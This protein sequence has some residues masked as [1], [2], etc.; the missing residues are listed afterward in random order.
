MD[1]RTQ[2]L[3]L[4]EVI[5]ATLLGGL[6]G[7]EREVASKPAGLRTHMLVALSATVL[8]NLGGTVVAA[9]PVADSVAADPIRIIQAV[10]V[11]VSFLGAGTILQRESEGHVQGLTTAASLLAAAT[12]GIAVGLRLFLLA[13]GTTALILV[14]NRVVNYLDDWLERRV[15]QASG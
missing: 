4:A 13:A 15:D 8:V 14:I 7:F 11:G 2:L 12:V 10:I 6:V 5:L 9:F 3:I 1:E